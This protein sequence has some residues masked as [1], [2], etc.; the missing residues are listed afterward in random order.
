VRVLWSAGAAGIV[1]ASGVC[2]MAKDY[3][4]IL[5]VP[6]NA[7]EKE[8]RAA[9]RRL[10]RQYHPD[11]NPGN[12]EAERRFKE[13]NAAYEVLS[14]PEKRRKYD[15]YGDQWQYADQIEE[16]R[17][18]QQ[19]AGAGWFGGAPGGGFEFEFGDLG[20]FGSIFDS[21][22]RRGRGR[23][24]T[25]RR[26]Q[27]IETPVE[28][29][30][31]EA[32]HGTTRTIELDGSE[33]CAS[34]GGTGVTS[35]RPCAACGGR[36]VVRRVKRLEV[37]IPPG[38]KTGS[39]VRVAGEG[40]AGVAGGPPGDLYLVVTVLPHPVFER[41]G[42]DLYAEVDVPYLDAILGG[43]VPVRTI[44]GR[45][46]LKIPPLTQNGQTFR[47]AGKGMPVLGAPGRRG[48]MYAKVRV[49]LPDR[50]SP[51][52]KRLLEELREGARAKAAV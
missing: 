22:F 27:D 49:R 1:F 25:P 38:V 33:P 45:V 52:E 16:M 10:A 11:V 19:E 5:G 13:I 47:L 4:E 50:L 30:L 6:R 9:Y 15:L 36:G 12:P 46:M 3:Y 14:D 31:E 7:S 18:R 40:Q 17:R 35:G 34:C 37:K 48:D 21:L 28:V 29:T 42:D 44:D 2:A 32:F 26:G 8:I 24:R 23:A 20:D 41:R 39:R 43:E 51:E